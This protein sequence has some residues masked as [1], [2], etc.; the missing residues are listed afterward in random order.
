[1]PL[2]KSLRGVENEKDGF[3]CFIDFRVCDYRV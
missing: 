3:D 2:L 1:M